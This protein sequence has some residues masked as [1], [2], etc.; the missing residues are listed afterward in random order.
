VAHDHATSLQVLDDLGVGVE[1]VHAGPR[2]DLGREATVLVHRAHGRDADG[3]AGDLVVLSR[4]RGH[5][6]DAGAVLGRHEVAGQTWN[7]LG[8]SAKNGNSGV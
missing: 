7:A 4:S 2:G 5:V 1:D 3:V 8:V 6:H